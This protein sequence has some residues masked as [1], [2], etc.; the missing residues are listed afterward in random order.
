MQLLNSA[1][2]A[3]EAKIEEA[4]KRMK[5]RKI[6]L[7][8]KAKRIRDLRHMM[9]QKEGSTKDETEGDSE[10]GPEGSDSSELVRIRNDRHIYN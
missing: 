2:K 10:G 5:R 7:E 9:N 4:N 6:Q 1:P 3:T 8:S